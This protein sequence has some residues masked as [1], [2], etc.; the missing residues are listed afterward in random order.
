MDESIEITRPSIPP[1]EEYIEEI[2]GI[3][4]RKWLTNN[5]TLHQQF[6]QKLLKFLK[7][8]N[9]EI[10][11][12]GHT[13]LETIL[14]LMELKGE[15]ITTPYT[16]P[17]TTHAIVRNGLEPVFSDIKEN[18]MNLD[19]DSIEKHITE[20]TSAIVPVHIFGNPCDVNEIQK[21][22]EEY[23]LKVIY[24]AAQA[25]G[26]EIDGKPI[27][28]FGDASIFSL[29]ATKSFNSIEGGIVSFKDNELKSKLASLKNF[30]FAESKGSYVYGMN[31]KM[32]EFQAAMGICNLRHYKTEIEKRRMVN[33]RY[34]DNLEDIPGIRL[35]Q[36]KPGALRNYSY[37]PILI[38]KEIFGMDRDKVNDILYENNIKS[39][40]YF[41]P[42]ITDMECYKNPH[43]N[44]EISTA[45]KIS[46]EILALPLYPDLP[47]GIV[48]YICE[49][50]RKRE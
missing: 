14:S 6:E 17:S 10:F 24:D 42:L 16:F 23:H 15:V 19:P 48:D 1:I 18:D 44:L 38:D 41:Y 9:I 11:V 13:A 35:I 45:R 20:K 43:R 36:G 37:F 31:A 30:G 2:R 32:N 7:V 22:A 4:E 3:W 29:H 21:I 34:V 5:G 25:F 50:I 33:D 28:S 12:N 47:L 26:V 46:E 49:M 8:S 27:G 39:R 40:K